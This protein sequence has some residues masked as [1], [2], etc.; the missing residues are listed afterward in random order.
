MEEPRLSKVTIT[1]F[2]LSLLGAWMVLLVT[3]HWGLGL[4]PESIVYVQAAKNFITGQGLSVFSGTGKALP[5]TQFPPLFPF[6][7]SWGWFLGMDVYTWARF[8]HAALFGVNIFLAG[9]LA[10]TYS[11]KL[12]SAVLASVFLLFSVHIFEAHVMLL[13][14]SLFLA[15]ALGFLL[16]LAL[17]LKSNTRGS[18][19]AA[20]LLAVAAGLTHVMGVVLILSGTMALLLLSSRELGERVRRTSFFA[21]C[22]LFPVILWH[23]WKQ[24]FPAPEGAG[25]YQLHWPS[26]GSLHSAI[27]TVSCWLL[28]PTAPEGVRWV[29]LGLAIGVVFALARRKEATTTPQSSQ[30]GLALL[31]FLGTSLAAVVVKGFLVR[32]G[33]SLGHCDL[34]L[35]YSVLFVL[36]ATNWHVLWDQGNLSA[37][38]RRVIIAGLI[39]FVGL[40]VFRSAHFG[41]GFYNSGAGYNSKAWVDSQVVRNLRALDDVPVYTNDPLAV[42]YLTGRPAVMLPR[43]C[44]Q[45][46]NFPAGEKIAGDFSR[47]RAV[48]VIFLPA[49]DNGTALAQA[50]PAVQLERYMGDSVADIYGVKHK[51]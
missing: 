48:A 36:L 29:V 16:A 42:Y 3:K 6:L 14:T 13:P 27:N 51:H 30:V 40:T 32:G 12:S 39:V 18:F 34:V 17:F 46:N 15:E 35:V 25:Y 10:F 47:L 49:C 11:R 38:V 28:P 8:L 4:G 50:I 22:T 41:T 23:V 9:M 45:L 44:Q 31:L 2:W 33:S 20:L 43:C 7:L 26:W 5:L 19:Y 24:I 37:G 1:L 21:V